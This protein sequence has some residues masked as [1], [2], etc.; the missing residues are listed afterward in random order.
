MAEGNGKATNGGEKLWKWVMRACA[1]AGFGVLLIVKGLEAS[2]AF[3]GL[4][5]LLFF[6]PEVITGKLKFPPSTKK[7]DDET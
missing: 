3:Y 7:D 5:T 2:P 6:G 1:V 4:L